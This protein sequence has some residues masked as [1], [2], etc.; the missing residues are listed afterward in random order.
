[1]SDPVSPNPHPT[2]KTV[3]DSS[4]ST[5][6]SETHAEFAPDDTVCDFLYSL[7]G[8]ASL[9][10]PSFATPVVLTT[11]VERLAK[12]LVEMRQHL[13]LSLPLTQCTD[14]VFPGR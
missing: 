11:T 8:R 7:P 13:C 10:F 5:D 9:F 6:R 2:L 14:Q 4:D 1:M 12:M 3:S